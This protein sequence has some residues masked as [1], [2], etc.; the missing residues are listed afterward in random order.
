M[1][2]Y[3][4]KKTSVFVVLLFVIYNLLFANSILFAQ[5]NTGNGETTQDEK[6]DLEQQLAELEKQI[7]EHQEKINQYQKEGKNLKGE[8]SSLNSKID[9]LNLQIKSVNLTLYKLNNEIENT[10]KSVNEIESKIENYKYILSKAI[11]NLYEADGQNLME[12]V[13]ANNQLSN[14]FNDVTS[15]VIIQNNL[16]MTLSQVVKLRQEMLAKKQELADEK[17]D[18]ENLKAIQQ[19]QK[20]SVQSVKSQKDS[21]LKITKGKESEYQKLLTKTK[22]TAA[23][24]RNRI[25][26]L[27]GGGELTFE[28]AYDYAIIA[29]KATGVRAALVL[30]VLHRESLFGQNTGRCGYKTAMK[31]KDIPVFLEILSKLGIDPDSMLVKVSCANRDGYYGGAMGPGQFIPSTWKIFESDIAR[32]TGNNPPSP[33]NNSDAFVATALYLKKYGADSKI[34]SEEKR[35]AATYYCG[36]NWRGYACSYYSSRVMETA[37]KFQKDIELINS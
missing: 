8:I 5:E 2:G 35:A 1:T 24:I 4:F 21:L 19:T 16:R 31:P 29:E 17:E 12:I 11:R 3:Q 22:E 10:Q 32:L 7:T 23:Q 6:R 27:L 14:F 9:K 30:A 20:A 25:F 34:T 15:I 28:K 18:A 33:W 26:E 36:N 37:Q 13:F